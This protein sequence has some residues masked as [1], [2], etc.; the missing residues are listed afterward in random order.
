[1]GFIAYCIHTCIHATE[2]TMV[3]I[4]CLIG[5]GGAITGFEEGHLK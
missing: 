4:F 5:H 1:M 2:Y 3:V